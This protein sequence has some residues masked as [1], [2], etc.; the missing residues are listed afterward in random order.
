MER[1]RVSE[2]CNT[3]SVMLNYE[4]LKTFLSTVTTLISN[5][6]LV[7]AILQIHLKID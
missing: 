7:V 3:D 5:S 1:D 4:F 6:Y 2:D